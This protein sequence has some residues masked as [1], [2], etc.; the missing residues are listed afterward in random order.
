MSQQNEAQA[1]ITVL[2]ARIE[3]LERRVS[4]EIAAILNGAQSLIQRV[5]ALE[6]K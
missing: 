3:S 2:K 4:V 5:T 1:E 6:Q